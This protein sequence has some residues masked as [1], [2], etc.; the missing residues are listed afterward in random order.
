MTPGRHALF[1][2]TSL[3][4]SGCAILLGIEPL[5][6]EL[7]SGQPD[8]SPTVDARPPTPITDARTEPAPDQE[9]VPDD[10]GPCVPKT[11]TATPTAFT[12]SGGGNEWSSTDAMKVEDDTGA[13]AAGCCSGDDSKLLTATAFGLTIPAAARIRGVRVQIR[14]KASSNSTMS[15]RT[16]R[17]VTNTVPT[18]DDLK[19]PTQYSTTYTTRDYGG[20]SILWGA[21]LSPSIVNDANFGVA[22]GMG[23]ERFQNVSAEVD[24]LRL[25]VTYCD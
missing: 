9:V 3:L 6:V 15:D 20:E 10:S 23:H 8:A 22:Y 7:K 13:G 17:L 11:A 4:V 25:S 24:V 16:V 5:E 2:L 1:V 14:V 21:A 18:G 19:N 12:T